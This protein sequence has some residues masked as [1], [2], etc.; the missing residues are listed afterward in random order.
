MTID[1]NSR[2]D[3][4]TVIVATRE[5]V[6][7]GKHVHI[8]SHCYLAAREGL[9]MED[10]TTL[11]P[12]VLIFTASDDYSGERMTNS[13]LPRH[14]TGG[15]VGAVRLGRHVIVGAGTVILP[16]VTIDTGSSV[17][18]MSLVTKSLSGWGVYCGIPARRLRARKKNLLQLEKDYL[19]DTTTR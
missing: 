8:S 12:G 18:A 14:L 3:D 19:A 17:G 7:I 16:N 15:P 9:V 6:T 4:F 13:T 5:P 1:D 10:F 2:I 11:A